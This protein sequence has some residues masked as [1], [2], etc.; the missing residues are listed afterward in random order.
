MK[1]V[2]FIRHGQSEGNI[3]P[4]YQS[5]DSPLSKE[6]KRQ[7]EFVG[8]RCARLPID[9]IISSTQLRAKTTADI[10]A[11]TT[12]LSVE[13]SDLFRERRKP[14]ALNGKPFSDSEAK[15]ISHLWSKS[16]MGMGSRVLDGESFEDLSVRAGKALN[17]LLQRRENNILVVTHGFYMRYL[18][19]R[20]VYGDNLTPDIFAPLARSLVKENTGIT[21]L[22]YATESSEAWGEAAPWQLWVWNDHAH[23]G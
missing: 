14:T 7:A 22:R 16:I 18:V 19:S 2:Y 10:I 17:Y 12:G 5:V 8:K 11:K 20:A 6:G 3:T 13:L 1:T 23:L 4:V 21:V 9:V 15:K